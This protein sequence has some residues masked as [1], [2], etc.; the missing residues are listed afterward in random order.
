MTEIT[1][2]QF[3]LL[4]AYVL[5][6]FIGL[7]GLAP[8][9]PVISRW[10]F[11]ADHVGLDL[12]PPVYALMAATALGLILTAFRWM[13]LDRAHSWMGVKRPVWDDRQLS[14]ELSGFDYLVQ[15]H[16]R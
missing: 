12:A 14:Q 4:V 5:P 9:L 8:V 2:K 6:G 1:T 3:G 15:N 16:F 13:I 10:L 7:T 11:P